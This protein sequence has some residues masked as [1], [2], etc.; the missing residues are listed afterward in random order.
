[1]SKADIGKCVFQFDVPI[2]KEKIDWLIDIVQSHLNKYH[3]SMCP[4]VKVRANEHGAFKNWVFI[5]FNL[6]L[7][8]YTNRDKHKNLFNP[9][10][11]ITLRFAKE[12]GFESYERCIELETQGKKTLENTTV[13]GY[14]VQI[15]P[16]TEYRPYRAKRFRVFE[17]RRHYNYNSDCNAEF[18]DDILIG[19]EDIMH[20]KNW[21]LP[22]EVN[23][24]EDDGASA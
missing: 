23:K 24:Y 9:V 16:C 6:R 1:M 21:Y 22:E 17:G 13:D 7:C 2:P 14:T 11:K 12:R 19:I 20:H 18:R 4:T 10:T 5:D 8:D 15:L 3:A